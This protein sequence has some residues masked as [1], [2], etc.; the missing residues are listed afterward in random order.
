MTILYTIFTR[1]HANGG[2]Y[3]S[4]DQIS[5]EL[6]K[7]HTVLIVSIGSTRSPIID[8][9]PYFRRHIPFHGVASFLAVNRSFK[10]M[11]SS[12]RPDLLHCFDT[13]SYNIVL[14]MPILW[15]YN[16]ILTKCGGPN[17]VRKKWQFAKQL[18]LFSY[19]NYEWFKA[20]LYFKETKL[21]LIANRVNS[22]KLAEIQN[23]SLNKKEGCF[24]FVRISRLGGTYDKTLLDCFRLIDNLKDSHLVHLYVIGKIQ[25]KGR[26]N[27]LV[28]Q[29]IKLNLP[30]TFI[31]D[32]RTNK[33]SDM[34]YLADCVIG[35]GRGL[36]E[37]MSLGIPTLTPC[38][39]SE[40]P[41]LVD[42][43]NFNSFFFTNFSERN[44]AD[45][46]TIKNS[47][48]KVTRMIDDS[49]YHN[50][51]TQSTL[52]LFNTHFSVGKIT[53]KYNQVYKHALLEKVNKGRLLR[54]NGRYVIR[55]WIMN[56][57]YL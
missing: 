50:F 44:I 27:E 30:V 3:H 48:E 31:T 34:L 2:H 11:I 16:I 8:S 10:E 56:N 28:E 37:A 18:I 51:L 33:A 24:N 15:K 46:E 32:E 14:A 38:K 36:M 19:E 42:E 52:G 9:N 23:R 21:Y 41:V 40:F 17:P 25:D 54:L 12:E 1:G 13:E 55:E 35:T 29:T 5:R 39:N 6:A 43:A 53:E 20:N 4:L 45:A 47:L 57:E 49:G 26:F 22:I 7:D